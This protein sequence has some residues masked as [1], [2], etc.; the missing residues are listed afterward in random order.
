MTSE[1][2]VSLAFA[3]SALPPF[4]VVYHDHFEFVWSCARRLG[5]PMDAIEGVVQDIFIV[6]HGRLKTLERPESLRSWLY[7]VVRTTVSTYHHE[8]HARIA[9]ESSKPLLDDEAIPMQPSPL[10]LADLSDEL[11]LLWTLLGELDPPNREV[12]VLAGIEEMTM[13]EIAEAI[14]IPLN[15]AHS[16]L[17]AACQEFEEAV[18]ELMI[19]SGSGHDVGGVA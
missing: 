7:S 2:S 10:D 11:K 9:R 1:Q 13:P 6:V 3:A 4:R 16:R 18:A 17:R 8:R 12:L 15:M 5:V 14:G 19:D